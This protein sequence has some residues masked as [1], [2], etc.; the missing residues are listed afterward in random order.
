MSEID[1]APG[2]QQFIPPRA[3]TLDE[4]RA[5]AR[6]CRGCELYRDATQ[7]VFGR[8]D[9]HARLVFV[10]EQPGDME[11]QKGLPFVGP[12]GRLL[13]RAVDDAGLD[14]GHIYLTNTV[15]HFRHELRGR[16]RI[17]QTPDQVHVT[18]CRP[19]LVAE[20]ARL[21]PEVVVVLGATA[22]KALL[23]PSFRVTRQ[24]GELLPWPAAA[25]RPQDFARVPVDSAGAVA[26]APPA[27]LLATIHPSAV[28]RA[29]DQDRA[30]AGL[31]A[32]LTTVAHALG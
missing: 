25:Q 21:R 19:W 11:D 4:L 8:G 3:D 7:T 14:P 15:K 30:Y 31:V 20:F 16:R 1:T 12:A 24:R 22:A 17:H 29:D 27:R 23:G 26:D 9:A 2:A 32:D 18:A 10:G 13:R 6:D 5:A 28:L